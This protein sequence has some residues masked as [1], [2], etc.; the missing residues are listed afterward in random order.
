MREFMAEW[1]PKPTKVK[2]TSS[3]TVNS[4]LYIPIGFAYDSRFFFGEI[5]HNAGEDG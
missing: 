2:P 1:F 4:F 5:D 3:Y